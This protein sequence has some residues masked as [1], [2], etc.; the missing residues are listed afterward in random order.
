MRTRPGTGWTRA[1]LV[2]GLLF[3]AVLCAKGEASKPN[4]PSGVLRKPIPDKLVVLTFDD[5]CAIHYDIVAPI[6]KSYGF[7][8]SFAVCDFDSFQTR[9]DWYMTYREMKELADDGFDISNHSAGHHQVPAP[10]EGRA[11]PA[12]AL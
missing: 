10:S 4:D 6:L 12:H 11:R 7:N 1:L 5:A 2:C 8:A 3:G 9:K